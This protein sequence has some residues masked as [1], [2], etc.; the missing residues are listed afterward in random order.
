M[1]DLSHLTA[2]LCSLSRRSP[3]ALPDPDAWPATLSDEHWAFSPEW[4]SLAGTPAFDAL[5]SAAQRRLALCELVNFFSLNIHGERSMIAGLARRLYAR[6]SADVTAYLHHFLEEESRHA[7]WFGAFCL[8]YAGR[9]YPDRRVELP[10]DYA[11]GEEE[12]LFFLRIV[13]FEELVDFYNVHMGGDARVHPLVAAIHRMHHRDETR[14]LAFGR[15]LVCERFERLRDG[16]SAETLAGVRAHIAGYLVATLRE[17]H[18]TDAYR[19]AGLADPAG[20]VE[21]S[22]ASPAAAARRRA[23]SRRCVAFLLQSG[24]LT[25]DPVS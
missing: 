10:R 18:S 23:A 11:P 24:I 14:H 5:A 3:A 1:H 2:R 21:R 25:E 13:V 17:Y 16:W 8:R 15:R 7:R 19:H 12:L 20:L 6:S 9:I 4:I 22:L